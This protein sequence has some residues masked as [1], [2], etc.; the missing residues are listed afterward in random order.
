MPT[1]A[2]AR[3]TTAADVPLL[4]VYPKHAERNQKLG[5]RG[6]LIR[7]VLPRHVFEPLR[8]ELRLAWLRLRSRSAPRR[9]LG[10]SELLVNVGVGPHGKP[11]W[12]NVDAFPAPGVNCVVDCRT[13]L[14]FPD[15]SVRVIYT[16]HFFEHL[17]SE[18]EV[19]RFLA[20]CHRV[21]RPGGLLRVIVPDMEQYLRAY[22]EEGWSSLERVRP[23]EP[24]LVD[25]YV[26]C[27]YN[28]K[29]ELVN[30]VF[31]QA[32][33]HKYAYDFE[34]LAA[35]LSRAGFSQIERSRFGESRVA[36]A[37]LD[38]PARRSE[39]LYVEAVR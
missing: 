39:S 21:L 10:A 5:W 27:S 4:G 19:P 9:Y 20:E 18:D 15:G 12:V 6:R 35:T 8:D 7:R 22:C 28:T 31:R 37:C 29:M 16:E 11:G 33:Q 13:S 25:P 17:D 32:H 30:A 24:G 36:E 26:K 2:S 1:G 3:T 23:L 14:P 38:H 34:T